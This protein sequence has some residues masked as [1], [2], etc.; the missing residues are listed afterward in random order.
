MSLIEKIIKPQPLLASLSADW[1]SFLNYIPCSL[2][3]LIDSLSTLVSLATSM[4]KVSLVL[5][6]KKFYTL[7]YESSG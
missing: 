1:L 7:K 5:F 6:F 4:P 3:Y 2:I